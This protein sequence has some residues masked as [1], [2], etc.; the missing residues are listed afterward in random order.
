MTT[1]EKQNLFRDS[2]GDGRSEATL[3]G[4]EAREAADIRDLTEAALEEEQVVTA[5]GWRHGGYPE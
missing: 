1:L 4:G 2:G 5:L 3:T